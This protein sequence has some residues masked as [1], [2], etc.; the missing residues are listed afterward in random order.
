MTCSSMHIE[1]SVCV[2]AQ[3]SY[4]TTEPVSSS[5]LSRWTYPADNDTE[6]QLQDIQ[7]FTDYN[8][9]L[10]V[11]STEGQEEHRINCSLTSYS[12]GRLVMA[13]RMLYPGFFFSGKKLGV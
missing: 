4:M 2:C 13:P 12:I 3:V 6:V 9:K 11:T 8:V 5:Y 1:W 7:P 10:E